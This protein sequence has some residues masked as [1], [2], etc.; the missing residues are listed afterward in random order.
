MTSVNTIVPL[1]GTFLLSINELRHM[2]LD[3]TSLQRA[4]IVSSEGYVESAMSHRFLILELRRKQKKP[5]WLGLE[6]RAGRSIFGLVGALG[7]VPQDTVNVFAS[8]IG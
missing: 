1:Y 6:R 3:H 4:E 2:I 5:I 8:N 7:S